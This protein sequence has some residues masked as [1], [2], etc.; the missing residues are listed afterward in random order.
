[1]PPV[2][3]TPISPRT[4]PFHFPYPYS[5]DPLPDDL[6][7]G[8]KPVGVFALL[9]VISTF[10]LFSWITYRLISWRSHYRTYVGYNQYVVLVYN[11]LLADMIQSISFLFSFH[12]ISIDKIIAPTGA[13]YGQAA[14]LHIGDV[15][16]G[17]F[18]LAIAIHT[19]L[20]VI[21]GYRPPY[22]LFLFFVVGIWIFAL[23]LTV[24]GPLMH[25]DRFFTRAGAWCWISQNYE[26]ER[27]WLHYI[28]IFIDE[29]G[30]MIIYGL[31]F[32]RL[33]GQLKSIVHVNS[34]S[35]NSVGLTKAARYMILY[36][37]IYMILTLPLAAGRMAAMTGVTLPDTYYCIAGSLMTSCGWLD[38]LLYTLTRRALISTELM[39]N[40]PNNS[41]G[42]NSHSRPTV[43][44]PDP[45]VSGWE[46]HSFD[47]ANANGDTMRTVTITGGNR[48]RAGGSG[49]VNSERGRSQT[50][51]SPHARSGSSSLSLRAPSPVGST[52]SIK[53]LVG[54]GG[55]T[56]ETKVEVHIESAIESDT[57]SGQMHLPT[58]SQGQN[59]RFKAWS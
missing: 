10:F 33:R 37:A 51:G 57:D 35:T 30:T 39:P 15:S 56:A 45:N 49:S 9:S 52:D 44:E 22:A 53:K 21:K 6:R 18:V 55:V 19:W 5:L 2:P 46:I 40:N 26:A 13:C 20:S 58:R 4:S 32:V 31:I 14:L 59:I 25:R 27:L 47:K 42:T 48:G 36:P 8:L 3:S 17:F 11:L 34:R 50:G 28:W 41:R 7:I 12:W 24:V 29:F 16:S 43:A 1:M 23:L 54:L 38:A